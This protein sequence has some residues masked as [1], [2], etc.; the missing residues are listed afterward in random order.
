GTVDLKQGLGDV[1]IG[2]YYGTSAPLVIHDR[3]LTNAFVKDVQRLYAPSGAVRAFNARTGVLEWV[4][5][6]VPPDMNPGTAE[7]VRNGAELTRGTPNSWGNLSADAEHG[8]VFVPTG[9]PSPDHYGGKE[10]RNMDYYGSSTIALDA[11]TG[12]VRW[13]FQT[14]H[15]DLWDYDVAAQPVL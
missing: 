11:D 10:R 13:H 4:F 9:N 15:H 6:P 8:I 7:Q 1:R 2:E 12:Q 5:D 3:V 14:V